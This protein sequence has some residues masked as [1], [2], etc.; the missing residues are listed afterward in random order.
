MKSSGDSDRVKLFYKAADGK[1]ELAGHLK[2][3]AVFCSRTAA[4]HLLLA[5]TSSV[6]AA[7]KAGLAEWSFPA[8]LCDSLLAGGTPQ[9]VI[10]ADGHRFQCPLSTLRASGT[11]RDIAGVR[12]YCLR[13][14]LFTKQW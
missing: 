1:M 3:H 4:T 6:T 14:A 8:E 10:D 7:R 12:S 2:G 9:L 13:E 11:V 5:G